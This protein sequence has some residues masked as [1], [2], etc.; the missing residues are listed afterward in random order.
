MHPR[1]ATID[2]LVLGEFQ[3]AAEERLRGHLRRCSPCRETYDQLI[4]LHR[5]L[6]GNPARPASTEEARMIRRALATVTAARAPAVARFPLW[7]AWAWGTAAAMAVVVAATVAGLRAARRPPAAAGW[8]SATLATL[9][10][11]AFAI[12]GRVLHARGLLLRGH[13][14]SDGNPILVGEAVAVAP[15]GSAGGQPG[16]AEVSVARGGAVRL[17]PGTTLTLGAGGERVQLEQGEIWCLPDHNGEPFVVATDEGEVRTIGTSFIVE[18]RDDDTS[19]R[20]LQG[21]VEVEDRDRRG[22]VRLHAEQQTRLAPGRQPE[23]ARRYAPARDR[24]AWDAVVSGL[25]RF[26]HRLFGGH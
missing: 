2:R 13:S 11:P 24:N 26:L 12:A 16:M 14:A 8:S 9:R 25:V 15:P 17:F 22:L 1:A 3:P 7:G 6:A 21:S 5:A 18:R 10:E 19:V 4:L 23:P 20:V